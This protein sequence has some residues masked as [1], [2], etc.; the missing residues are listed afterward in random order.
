MPFSF[1]HRSASRSM[2]IRTA[3]AQAPLGSPATAVPLTILERPGSYAG[4]HVTFFRVFDPARAA[5][6][7][8]VQPRT[9]RDLDAHPELIAESGHVERDGGVV[10]TRR[11]EQDDDA[12]APSRQP[13]DRTAHQDDERFV[14]W[15]TRK[16]GAYTLVLSRPAAA[17]L[18][19]QSAAEGD[20]SAP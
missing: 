9:F 13:A 2:T 3:L 7:G 18:N 20:R 15:D 10:L 16:A 14:F 4:R 17:W 5:S 19:A 11:P 12:A 8:G 6:A 1:A